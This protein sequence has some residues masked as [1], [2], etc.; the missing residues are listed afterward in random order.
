MKKPIKH[1]LVPEHKKISEREK[2]ELLKKY[3]ITIKELPRILISDPAI[4]HLDVKPGDIIKIIRKS[5]TS[6]ES[7]YYRVVSSE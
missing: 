2:Q 1:I 7:I 5:P 3:N 6:G 4:A